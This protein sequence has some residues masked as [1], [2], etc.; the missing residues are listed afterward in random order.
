VP[1]EIFKCIRLN[2]KPRT[3]KASSN[4]TRRRISQPVSQFKLLK[5]AGQHIGTETPPFSLAGVSARTRA[6]DRSSG[7]L[8]PLLWRKEE[9]PG[10]EQTTDG[11]THTRAAYM[12]NMRRSLSPKG[13]IQRL[14]RKLAGERKVVGKTLGKS[15]SQKRGKYYLLDHS[16]R[17]T[18]DLSLRELESIARELGV[19]AQDENLSTSPSAPMDGVAPANTDR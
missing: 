7:S 17:T 3:P 10:R 4:S 1:E 18:R 5:N 19:L 6:A 12:A 15:R 14:N 13:L 8:G 2:E 9:E 11:L 16:A